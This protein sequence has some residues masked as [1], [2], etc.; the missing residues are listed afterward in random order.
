MSNIFYG[1][2]YVLMLL[3]V[4]GKSRG[5]ELGIIGRELYN[6]VCKVHS[7]TNVFLAILLVC[8]A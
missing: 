1:L 3:H 8:T 4:L 6:W 2:G 5:W 7:L